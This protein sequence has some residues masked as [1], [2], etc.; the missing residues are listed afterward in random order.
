MTALKHKPVNTMTGSELY[1]ELPSDLRQE[2]AKKFGVGS[3]YVGQILKGTTAKR[4][5]IK[6]KTIDKRTKV[7]EEA[8]ESL[9]N[10]RLKLAELE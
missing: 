7:I 9:K 6:S 3:N 4:N 1:E 5:K 2:I 8:R 10:Y